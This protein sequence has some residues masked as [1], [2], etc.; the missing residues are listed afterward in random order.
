MN[1]K[2][3][4]LI[5]M[6]AAPNDGDVHLEVLLRLMTILMDKPFRDNLLSAKT[7]E[8]FL[9]IVD[10]KEKE[11]YPDEPKQ[12]VKEETPKC[13][14]VL[15]V[16]ACPTGIAHTYMA[17]EALEKTGREMGYPLKAE[18]NGSGGA[19]N[20]LTAEEIAKADGIIIAADKAV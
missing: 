19:K 17:A 20:V 3:S 16:T 13:Y 12:E 14:R 6:I 2:P 11:K 7:K 4:N 9:K 10:D 15:A 18:T 8:E 5:F 1:N